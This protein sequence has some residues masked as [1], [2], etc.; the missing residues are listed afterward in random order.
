MEPTIKMTDSIKEIAQALCQVQAIMPAADK[1][2]ENPHF[3]SKFATLA[4]IMKTALPILS[5]NK[6]S[7]M[8]FVTTMPSGGSGLV[9]MLLH[10]SGEYIMS[11]MP[12]LLTKNDPQGQG[13]AITYA[14][15]YGFMSAIGM[16]S[17]EDDDGE[18][19]SQLPENKSSYTSPT[20]MN[21]NGQ[22]CKHCGSNHLVVGMTKP[23]NPRN[24]NRP[25]WKC[26][27]CP[28]EKSFSH[29]VKNEETIEKK[30]EEPDYNNMPFEIS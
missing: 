29:W 4:T 5:A 28:P 3:R 25:Y 6:L 15:R 24:P 18:A 16:V 23:D 7:I 1:D 19:A 13:S 20:K 22:V 12:L 9:T 30:E 10:S 14:R 26:L 11:T 2:G 21:T 17:E 8:Q 27:D